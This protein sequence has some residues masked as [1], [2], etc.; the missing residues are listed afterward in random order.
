[1]KA[2]LAIDGY[3][4]AVLLLTDATMADNM[5]LQRFSAFLP[6]KEHPTAPAWV[7][8]GERMPGMGPGR[9]PQDATTKAKV[10]HVHDMSP[11]DAA[12]FARADGKGW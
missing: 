9:V 8:T 5:M 4:H 3:G 1:M 11:D 10:E 7:I 2:E 6:M 12:A